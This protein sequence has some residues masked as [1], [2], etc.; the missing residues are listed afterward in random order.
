MEKKI[1]EKAE[2]YAAKACD[3]T[4]RKNDGYPLTRTLGELKQDAKTDFIAGYSEAMKECRWISVSERLPE[5]GDNDRIEVLCIM[6]GKHRICD[7]ITGGGQSSFYCSYRKHFDEVTSM[8][9]HWK[10][11]SSF[12]EQDKQQDNG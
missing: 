4:P 9:S 10:Y 11:L 6:N 12:T 3:T 5:I 1:Q 2:K 8:V 7:F